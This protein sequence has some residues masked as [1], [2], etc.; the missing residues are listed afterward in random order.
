LIALAI[1]LV[2]K[3]AY[4]DLLD[5]AL[6]GLNNRGYTDPNIGLMNY[7]RPDYS[8]CFDPNE[9]EMNKQKKSTTLHQAGKEKQKTTPGIPLIVFFWA[10]GL[11]LLGYIG[12]RFMFTLHPLHW[13][14][15]A[16][17]V[18]LGIVIGYIWYLKRGDIGLI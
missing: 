6:V 8:P 9:V 2:R 18:L 10:F 12:S 1:I 17:G 16:G 7:F 5:L 4:G 14:S 15:G 3:N 11:G 13:L